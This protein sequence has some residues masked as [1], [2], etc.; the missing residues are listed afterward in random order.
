M[1]SSGGNGGGGAGLSTG[2][3]TKVDITLKLSQLQNLVKRDP[4]GYREDYEA[5]IVRLQSE[6][7]ILTIS[8]NSN[9]GQQQHSNGNGGNGNGGR[10][11]RSGDTTGGSGGGS[12]GSRLEELIQFAAATSSS[13]YKGKESD[14]IATILIGL[15]VGEEQEEEEDEDHDAHVSGGG[16]K[17][18][19][20]K[21]KN[22]TY[23]SSTSSNRR[24]IHNMTT[25]LPAAA[26]QL[27]RDI[28]KTCVSALILM[29][30]KGV[31]E[32]LRLLE[33]FFRIMAVVPDKTLREIL[34]KHLVNDIRNINKKGKRNEPVNRSIQSFLHRVVSTHGQAAQDASNTSLSSEESATDIA[35]KRATGKLFL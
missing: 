26:L 5:Q 18:Q 23:S 17:Q 25:L 12:G 10:K 21:H 1:S 34:Y 16:R 9:S 30:N 24:Q 20:K 15:L 29:R 33:L 7:N 2:A 4:S 3:G 19:K 35:A 11:G 14:R 32:P 13:S 8:G 27:P 6:C 31:L 28:R 22:S